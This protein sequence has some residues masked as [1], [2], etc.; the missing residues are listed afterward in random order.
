MSMSRR[1]GP[2]E[3]LEYAQMARRVVR[4]FGERFAAE[5]DEPELAELFRLREEVDVALGCAVRHMR[6][7]GGV[8]W[9]RI[10]RAVGMTGEGARQR[11]GLVEDSGD[12]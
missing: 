10:G 11:W 5:G 8:S 2:V 7:R 12:E 3:L 9:A 6:A 1:K 4:R